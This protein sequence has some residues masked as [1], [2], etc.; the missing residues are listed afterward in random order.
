MICSSVGRPWL[1]DVKI[2][3]DWENNIMMI[4]MNNTIRIIVVTN[5]LGIEVKH[6]EVLLCY[7]YQNGITYEE[8]II[9]LT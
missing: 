1:K 5:Y 4:Q 8:D 3:H 6:L 7:D 2:I 9:F